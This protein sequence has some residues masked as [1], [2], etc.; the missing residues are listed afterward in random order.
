MNSLNQGKK[1]NDPL[2][3]T[4]HKCFGWG[5]L[6]REQWFRE[7]NK[8]MKESQKKLTLMH[9]GSLD[10]L[11]EETKSGT[12]SGTVYYKASG[13]LSG[14][15]VTMKYTT[16]ADFYINNDPALG[17]YF[18]LNGNSD[19][20]ITNVTSQSGSMK[21]SVVC[22]GMYPG[23]AYYDGIQIKGGAAG[24]GYYEVEIRDLNG[25]VV[26]NKDHVDWLV[27]ED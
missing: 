15:S 10:A 7:Y 8:T 5:A 20:E 16:Y 6:T 26:L 19:T 25:S 22:T 17:V 9:K 13:G 4:E 14:A 23:T 1:S 11:G 12:I 18:C 21:N 27:G 2:T 3:D 24:G